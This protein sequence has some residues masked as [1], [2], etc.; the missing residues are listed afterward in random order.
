MNFEAHE[1]EKEWK[2]QDPAQTEEAFLEYVDELTEHEDSTLLPQLYTQLARCK[3]L[4]QDAQGCKAYLQSA[5][6]LIDDANGID[7]IIPLIRYHLER[8]RLFN[9]MQ[10]ED[11][12]REDF[13][14]A[15]NEAVEHG[16]DF[17]AVDAAHMLGIISEGEVALEWNLKAMQFAEDSQDAKTKSWLGSLYNNIGWTMHG[18]GRF[19]QALECFLN[20]ETWYRERLRHEEALIAHW[21][22]SKMLRLLN[23]TD[24]ALRELYVIADE[25]K[26]RSLPNDGYLVEEI[27]ECLLAKGHLEQAQ[28]FFAS[29]YGILSQDDWLLRNEASRIERLKMLG[30]C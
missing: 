3:S 20:N 21:S 26:Q 17:H 11:R 7:R 6:E 15:W 16:I 4:L 18:L 28:P 5:K 19:D 12:G 27:G 29:A 8:G 24:E 13:L 9:S 22:M 25:R 23:R 10:I 2:Y 30:K 1:F 14:T